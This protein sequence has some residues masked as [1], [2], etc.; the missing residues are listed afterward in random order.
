MFHAKASGV[1]NDPFPTASLAGKPVVKR[2][3]KGTG[4]QEKLWEGLTT[5]S[6][7]MVDARAGSGK[8]SSCREGMWRLLQAVPSTKIIYSV[9]GR[10]NADEFRP[11]CP[12]GVDVGTTHSFGYLACKKAFGSQLEKNKS[13]L[14]MDETREGR[15]LPR[16]IRKSVS[17]LIAAAKN[18]RL[19][20]NDPALYSRLVTLMKHMDI[21]AYG[22]V[23]VICEWAEALLG[24]SAGWTEV[25]DFDD[26]IWM[27][28]LHGLEFTPCDILFLDE[29]QDWNPAQHAMIPLMCKSG[30]VV[31]V[32]DP[33]QAIYVWRGAD[34]E[35]MP[36]LR[37]QLG[38]SGVAD[39]PLTVTFRC[40]KSH[41]AMAQQYVS[42]LEAH[43]SNRDGF[44][45][46]LSFS[47]LAR[48]AR[49]GDKIIC[50]TNAPVIKAALRMVAG[51]KR[52]V[53]KGRAVGDQLVNIVRSCRDCN[54]IALLSKG[55][56]AWKG[57]ELTRL[58][59]LD[60]VEDVVEAVEDRAAGLQ[61]VLS[62]CSSP[63]EVEGA[64]NKL[65]AESFDENAINFSTIHRAKGSEA[66]RIWLIE[67]PP[68]PTK[69]PWQIQ[70]SKNL[71]YVALTRSKD[72]LNIIDH[73]A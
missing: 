5:V 53:V 2:I 23:G 41:V 11:A 35:S 7:A 19:L 17:M 24:K 4:Q 73:E 37:E 9:Y 12:P 33:Y 67:V 72:T 64:I 32:G 55:V 63:V 34:P 70:Q 47:D 68:K 30:R 3:E 54:T 18:A 62:F 58:A 13:Y 59:D 40:P 50:P 16:F 20:P 52:V 66:E 71:R 8:S 57:R 45:N 43:E 49:P 61:A 1:S 36:R 39:Y 6:H 15:Q 38:K 60:G 25:I 14:M 10:E 29:V 46:H 48:D 51:G 31:A 21:N 27:P 44:I 26:M 56:E 69:I 42:D 22:R 28:S 65:F